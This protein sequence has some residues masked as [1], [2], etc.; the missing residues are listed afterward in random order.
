MGKVFR[1]LRLLSIITGANFYLKPDG[2]V[3]PRKISLTAARVKADSAFQATMTNALHFANAARWSGRIYPIVKPFLPRKMK[4][5]CHQRMRSHLFEKLRSGCDKDNNILLSAMKGFPCNRRSSPQR[6]LEKLIQVKHDPDR[7]AASVT[8]LPMIPCMDI[9]FPIG[10]TFCNVA[11][12]L[13]WGPCTKTM[14]PQ[15]AWHST[16]ATYRIN[17]ELISGASLSLQYP[18]ENEGLLL[19]AVSIRFFDTS[20]DER[21]TFPWFQGNL[22]TFDIFFCC[23]S[24]NQ[25]RQSPV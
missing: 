2:T 4:I 20:I 10:A 7:H 19:V 14:Q 24:H 13:G 16:E 22:D 11:L 1:K 3:S 8:L 18:S 9:N 6:S 21:E 23:P 5:G 15:V 12:L 17:N 25:G